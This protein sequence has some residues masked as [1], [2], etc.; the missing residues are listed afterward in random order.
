MSDVLGM[1][2]GSETPEEEKLVIRSFMS[3]YAWC[4][5]AKSN[6]STICL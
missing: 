6:V 3:Q 4:W 1:Q 5:Q 2:E